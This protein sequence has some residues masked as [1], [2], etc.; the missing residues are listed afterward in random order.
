MGELPRI[1]LPLLAVRDDLVSQWNI[2]GGNQMWKT[3]LWR[4]TKFLV[5]YI[6]WV[7]LLGTIAGHRFPLPDVSI[8]PATSNNHQLS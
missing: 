3:E 1:N 5:F 6:R 8:T 4:I 2:E 7:F